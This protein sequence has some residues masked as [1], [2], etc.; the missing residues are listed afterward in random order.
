MLLIVSG[1]HEITID[2]IGE[3][4]DH[5]QSEAGHGANIIMGVGEDESLE[6]SIAV[7]II[8]TGFNVEQQDEI[9]NT[10][11][12][13]VVHTLGLEEERE[14]TRKKPVAKQTPKKTS[15]VVRHTLDFDEN[16]NDQAKKKTENRGLANRDVKDSNLTTTTEDMRNINVVYSEVKAESHED[17]NSIENDASDDFII[18]PVSRTS[19]AA[20]DIKED[21]VASNYIEEE[22]Q[23]TLTFDLPISTETSEN[24]TTDEL[25]SHQLNEE[26]KDILVNDHVELITVEETTDKG[27]IRYVLDDY[28]EVESGINKKTSKSKEVF[29]DYDD[30]IVFEKKV[31]KPEAAEESI[32][33]EE[34]DPLESP[35]SDLLKERANERRLKMKAF[36]YKF[37]SSK[38]DDI[39][40]VPA[41][42]RQGVNLK[43]AKHS[44]ETDRSRTSLGLDDND[45]IQLRNNNSFLHDNVD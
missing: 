24:D 34:V 21:D 27:S 13:K 2:E 28:V 20:G 39:E 26:V 23:I 15:Q 4:N 9:S 18:H 3:I 10:E 16:S 25:V 1:S 42:K 37:N 30:N 40:K 41:Y 29:D 32:T 12:K 5:I 35:I 11:T 19:N 17:T 43:E 36:N 33:E 14:M 6:E 7:T 45:D 31:V 44:S 38:I 22:K 8:A